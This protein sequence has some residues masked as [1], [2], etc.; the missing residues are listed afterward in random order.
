VRASAIKSDTARRSG[1]D[2]A[3]S[4]D[5]SAK[6]G[7]QKNPGCAPGETGE[8][9]TVA[10]ILTARFSEHDMCQH[11]ILFLIKEM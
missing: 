5:A 2:L 11:E 6:G 1:D 3:I 9:V 7:V 8:G 4:T 10:V